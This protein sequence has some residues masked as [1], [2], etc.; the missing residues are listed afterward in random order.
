[1]VFKLVCLEITTDDEIY[2]RTIYSDYIPTQQD[3]DVYYKDICGLIDAVIKITC[4]DVPADFNTTLLTFSEAQPTRY[5]NYDIASGLSNT[6]KRAKYTAYIKQIVDMEQS[7]AELR[8]H[9]QGSCS[10]S[11]SEKEDAKPAATIKGAPGRYKVKQQDWVKDLLEQLESDEIVPSDDLVPVE[12]DTFIPHA[13]ILTPV[14]AAVRE[15]KG[16]RI[17]LDAVKGKHW[18]NLLG[19]A[20]FPDFVVS[21]RISTR[22]WAFQHET[23]ESLCRAMLAY[24]IASQDCA[25]VSGLSDWIPM[26]DKELGLLM[27][28]YKK[29]KVSENL[30]NRGSN[31][32]GIFNLLAT[33]ESQCLA[34]ALSDKKITAVSVSVFHKYLSYVCQALGLPREQY[35]GVEAVNSIVRR[36]ERTSLGFRGDAEPVVPGWADIWRVV[37]QHNPSAERLALFLTTLDAWN[38]MEGH[39]MTLGTRQE[40]AREWVKIY[41]ENELIIERTAEEPSIT[42]YTETAKWCFKYLPQ[43][44]FKNS[45]RKETIGPAYTNMG[46]L[47]FRPGAYKIVRGV[48]FKKPLATAAAA[49][50]TAAAVEKDS[51]EGSV[52]TEKSIPSVYKDMKTPVVAEPKTRAKKEAKATRIIKAHQATEPEGSFGPQRGSGQSSVGIN[53]LIMNLGHV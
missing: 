49:A 52:S 20:L 46:F 43:D 25:V 3:L 39:L 24:Y 47:K 37:M 28:A 34:S 38:P 27:A 11:E 50:A 33:I 23:S 21:R 45:L 36:W 42:L 32:L 13:W 14:V 26:A 22:G 30:L 16:S 5:P 19:T 9:M 8:V 17:L 15:G 6:E 41:V 48:R 2:N 12:S 4:Y 53:E 1:M 35:A 10:G 7:R 31:P 29:I 18:E 40:I 51:D 44:A